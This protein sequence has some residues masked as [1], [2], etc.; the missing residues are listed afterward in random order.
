[1]PATAHIRATRRSSMP[2]HPPTA[3]T[4]IG[5]SSAS[6]MNSGSIQNSALT[7]RPATAHGIHP[8]FT[9]EPSQLERSRSQVVLGEQALD[10]AV[11]RAAVVD[12]P[13]RHLPRQLQEIPVGPQLGEAEVG[14]ARLAR[15]EQLSFAAELQIYFGKL[16]TVVARRERLQTR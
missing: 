15:T 7:T 6:G 9:S 8:R 13:P 5:P 11:Q 14:Q 12:E 4:T 16:E 3:P 1:M 10:F 2:R